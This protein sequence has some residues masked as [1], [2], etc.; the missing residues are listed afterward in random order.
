MSS[1]IFCCE[2]DEILSM[3]VDEN[4]GELMDTLLSILDSEGRLDNY[5]A[6][7]FEKIIEM[8]LRTHTGQTI[9]HLNQGGI[10][11]FLRFVKHVNNYSVMQIIQRLMLP[12]IPFSVSQNDQEKIDCDDVAPQCNWSFL[13]ETCEILCTKLVED[14]DS[15]NSA[16]HI[17]DL[18]ITVLQLSPPETL[19]I[20]NLCSSKCLDKLFPVALRPESDSSSNDVSIAA[21]TVLESLTA[22][23][24]ESLSSAEC[25]GV[26]DGHIDEHM[27]QKDLTKR[28]LENLYGALKVYLPQIA[29]ELTKYGSAT[30]YSSC[31]FRAQDNRSYNKLGLKAL[32]LV[33]FV[34]SIIRLS[35]SDLDDIICSSVLL[36]HCVGLLFVF[37]VNS[38]LH[39]S[40]QRMISMIVEGGNARRNIQRHLIAECN[41]ISQIIAFFDNLN[42]DASRKGHFPVTGHIVLIVNTISN[43]MDRT[44]PDASFES[45]NS[46]YLNEGNDSQSFD[47][48]A[49]N[50]KN[51][52]VN[53]IRTSLTESDQLSHWLAF[54]GSAYRKYMVPGPFPMSLKDSN[55]F[56]A[57]FSATN[58]VFEDRDLAQ[59]NDLSDDEDDDDDDDADSRINNLDEGFQDNSGS[60]VFQADFANFDDF[61]PSNTVASTEEESKPVTVEDDPFGDSSV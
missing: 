55:Q 34:E 4:K 45:S 19:F 15:E 53:T 26:F 39:I 25:S 17:S 30:S 50:D 32:Q 20:S 24:C 22:R 48:D 47:P 6:G 35:N 3:L 37:E 57:H 38:L 14:I 28:S 54:L 1:E 29:V 18:L 43:V 12:H 5:L 27:S 40:I 49:I 7:Y 51:T 52:M 42:I 23:L 9:E 10:D 46:A 13:S 56:D 11:L 59:S 8:L 61:A 2:I 31:V 36:K 44:T 16:A 58:L 33:K 21:L 60:L 41:L